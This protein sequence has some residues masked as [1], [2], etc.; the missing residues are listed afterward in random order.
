MVMESYYFVS[1]DPRIPDFMTDMIHSRK[2][3]Q[4][5]GFWDDVKPS[6]LGASKPAWMIFDDAWVDEVRRGL[7][8]CKVFLWYPLYCTSPLPNSRTT[9]S[10]L[11]IPGL[12]YG[13]MTNNLTSQ[14]AVMKLGGVP[15]DIVSNFNPL[16]IVLLIP[17]MDQIV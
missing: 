12:A 3:V 9:P 1:H 5:P 17:I 7:L 4:Q 8:A 2:N 14:A 11:T 6:R 13:Q 16:F 15:N 10:L